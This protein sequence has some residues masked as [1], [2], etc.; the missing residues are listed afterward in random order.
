ML[1]KMKCHVMTHHWKLHTFAITYYNI[2]QM[3][4]IHRKGHTMLHMLL[5]TQALGAP[6]MQTSGPRKAHIEKYS[7]I[8]ITCHQ[9]VKQI[10]SSIEIN[11]YESKQFEF[12]AI[13]S[14]WVRVNPIWI[15]IWWHINRNYIHLTE[16]GY[17]SK[18]GMP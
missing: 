12:H 10:I 14:N 3:L 9:D 2:L 8:S 1:F 17:A 5:Q 16:K 6:H 13:S 11:H 15:S 4:Y 18:L 7:I